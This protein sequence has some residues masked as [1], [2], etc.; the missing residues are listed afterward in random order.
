MADI[1]ET[2]AGYID[3]EY[4][5]FEQ[6]HPLSTIRKSSP[7]FGRDDV[8]GSFNASVLSDVHTCGS[9]VSRK[10]RQ[11]LQ[12]DLSSSGSYAAQ[13]TSNP[14]VGEVVA[15][16]SDTDLPLYQNRKPEYVSD[17]SGRTDATANEFRWWC[18]EQEASDFSVANTGEDVTPIKMEEATPIEETKIL[19]KLQAVQLCGQRQISDR[20]R[21][22]SSSTYEE[23][24]NDASSVS[25]VTKD[26]SAFHEE[27]W[28]SFMKPADYDE[29]I[30]MLKQQILQRLGLKL[31]NVKV[32]EVSKA[33][34]VQKC[35]A[36]AQTC[37][38]AFSSAYKDYETLWLRNVNG[39]LA[40]Q[41]IK[42]ISSGQLMAYKTDQKFIESLQSHLS[43]SQSE[44]DRLL[45]M[46][47]EV[48]NRR[49]NSA[50]K[51]EML[52]EIE[53]LKVQNAKL[54]REVESLTAKLQKTT[55]LAALAERAKILEQKLSEAKTSKKTLME[56]Y[57]KTLGHMKLMKDRLK[58]LSS[59]KVSKCS[60]A[61]S[62][63]RNNSVVRNVSDAK[64]NGA[65]PGGTLK[66][67]IKRSNTTNCVPV[68]QDRVK[69]AETSDVYYLPKRS[70]S[71]LGPFVVDSKRRI[72]ML[73]CKIR[74]ED[75][76]CESQDGGV[77]LNWFKSIKQTFTN[78][79]H[80]SPGTNALKMPNNQ[81][82]LTQ[83]NIAMNKR[84]LLSR[85]LV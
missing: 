46:Q 42:V 79:R 45:H 28:S 78:N 39:M 38:D 6:G 37:E 11:G 33:K 32:R 68:K 50:D 65:T 58:M 5:D 22:D 27:E 64:N 15:C 47:P 80:N 82:T 8:Q 66:G 75:P 84:H 73:P 10:A 3:S 55:E 26:M 19:S 24:F 2:S 72:P 17:E 25:S 43:R 62:G 21:C 7:K 36:S 40:K 16:D 56:N 74:P 76:K 49:D 57:T 4:S 34:S 67:C 29:E 60:A 77:F 70:N 53:A 69:F 31:S 14:N 83:Q 23:D 48:C 85:G 52:G 41:F 12:M 44:I 9:L 1:L 81:E 18:D 54:K 61:E 63:T 30:E 35:D 20:T 51:D 59:E 71:E 13:S